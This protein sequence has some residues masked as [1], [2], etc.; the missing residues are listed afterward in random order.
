MSFAAPVLGGLLM[1]GAAINTRPPAPN[2]MPK[3]FKINMY[4]Y[5][6]YNSNNEKNDD[7]YTNSIKFNKE[8]KKHN[9]NCKSKKDA[10]DKAQQYGGGQPPEGPHNDG[11]GS[12][13]HAT[14]R[15][16]GKSPKKIPGVHF[17]YKVHKPFIYKI[18]V[19]DC[20]SK[21]AEKFGL[22]VEMIQKWNN[23]KDVNKIIAGNTLKLFLP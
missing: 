23:I 22:S 2:V 3:P 16:G 10:K 13:Y 4:N 15:R 11:Y 21:I 14:R 17:M 18:Q 19:G 12:H 20:L 7:N 5:Q 1:G 9:I 8:H 6:E